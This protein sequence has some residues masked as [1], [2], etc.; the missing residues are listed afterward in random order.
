MRCMRS[1]ILARPP[2]GSHVYRMKVSSTRLRAQRH[3]PLC[4]QFDCV[5]TARPWCCTC[6]QSCPAPVRW[7]GQST[8]NMI[9]CIHR[10]NR[11]GHQS[12][13]QHGNLG[14]PVEDEVHH[15]DGH[16]ART[17]HGQHGHRCAPAVL[18]QPRHLTSCTWVCQRQSS[19]IGD[20]VVHELAVQDGAPKLAGGVH[21]LMQN[22]SASAYDATGRFAT[23]Q[24]ACGRWASQTV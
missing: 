5:S 2:L 23:L 17:G 9:G 24:L 11:T 7:C 16:L 19:Q 12:S 4:H 8:D 20:L 21:H 6:I 18:D 13:K 3:Q 1:C 10:D 22:I 14:S 15:A